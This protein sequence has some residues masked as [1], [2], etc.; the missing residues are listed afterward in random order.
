MDD[1]REYERYERDIRV[2][3]EYFSI[4]E[5][6]EGKNASRSSGKIVNISLGGVFLLSDTPMEQDMPVSMF[7]KRKDESN[8]RDDVV[9]IT[10][11]TVLRSGHVYDDFVM[12]KKFDLSANDGSYFAVVKFEKP[13]FDLTSVL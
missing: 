2:E 13:V 6:E 8:G 11:G 1:R 12:M 3:Y 4:R 5:T 7:F 9:L 10:S